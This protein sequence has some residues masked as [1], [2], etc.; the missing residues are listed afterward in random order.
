MLVGGEGIYSKVAK[1]VSQGKLKV[2]DTGARGIHGQAPTTAFNELEE[3]VWLM[4]DDSNPKGRP[5]VITNV[6]PG[7]LDDPNKQFGWTMGS[8]YV[9][10]ELP[11]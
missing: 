10:G 9:T 11:V 4:S 6:R 2:Y 3:G 1:Q 8:Q 5:F 7:E